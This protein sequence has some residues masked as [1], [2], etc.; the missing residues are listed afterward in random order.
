M[1]DQ[2]I[3][4]KNTICG[5]QCWKLQLDK[6]ITQYSNLMQQLLAKHSITQIVNPHFS[7]DLAPW[8]CQLFLNAARG[9]MFQDQRS[10]YINAVA[11]SKMNFIPKEEFQMSL[12]LIIIL[13]F[14]P[15]GILH[16]QSLVTQIYI[17]YTMKRSI[18]NL[19]LWPLASIV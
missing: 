4:C 14:K 19:W 3:Q 10:Q 8:K 6:T 9:E 5:R 15:S 2:F 13:Y 11:T 18:V 7:P 16:M 17:N 12:V 1:L